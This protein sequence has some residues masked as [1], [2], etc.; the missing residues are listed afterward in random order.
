MFTVVSVRLSGGSVVAFE[1]VLV[2]LV[3][4]AVMFPI[5]S[6]RTIPGGPRRVVDGPPP[7]PS[8]VVLAVLAVVD[9]GWVDKVGLVVR[10][11]IVLLNPGPIGVELRVVEVLLPVPVLGRTL[12]L[13]GMTELEDGMMDGELLGR[14]LELGVGVAV[15][16]LEAGL[17]EEVD[18]LVVVLKHSVTVFVTVSNGQLVTVTVA[19]G[20]G[21]ALTVTTVGGQAAQRAVASSQ[22]A[23]EAGCVRV[24]VIVGGGMGGGGP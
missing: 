18:V 24:M 3:T 10:G 22:M 11:G 6:R 4:I 8:C 21:Q 15:A 9:V 14:I 16:E 19:R 12:E 1:K 20:I 17:V 13:E 23:V 5:I 2:M 7:S